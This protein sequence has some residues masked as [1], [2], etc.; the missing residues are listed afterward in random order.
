MSVPAYTKA[1]GGFV[2]AHSLPDGRFL[3]EGWHLNLQPFDAPEPR[4]DIHYEHL[5]STPT[6]AVETVNE[7]AGWLDKPIGTDKA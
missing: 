3:I 6:E 5:A 4:H 1:A 2:T 7:F